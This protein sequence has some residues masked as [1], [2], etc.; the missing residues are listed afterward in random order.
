MSEEPTKKKNKSYSNL[1]KIQ[2][3]EYAEKVS[4]ETAARKFGVH[5][6]TIRDWCKR[7]GDLLDAPSKRKRLEGM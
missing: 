5:S 1:I 7:K 4:K 2:A 3:I 6:K